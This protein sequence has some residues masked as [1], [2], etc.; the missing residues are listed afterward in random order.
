[1]YIKLIANG[2]RVIQSGDSTAWFGSFGRKVGPWGGWNWDGTTL[3]AKVDRYGMY[4]LFWA[5]LPD[6]VALADSIGALLK[7][8]VS[9]ELDDR[10]IAA[11]LR[12]GFFLGEDTPFLNVRSFPPLGHIRWSH[13]DGLSVEGGQ[14]PRTPDN[15]SSRKEIV[16]G[17]VERFRTAMGNSLPEDQT[18]TVLP[19]SG[20]RDSRHIAL[21]LHRLGF[22]PGLV[23]S[24]RHFA[25]RRDDDADIAAELCAALGW[26]IEIVSQSDDPVGGE[27]RKNQIFDCLTDEHAWLMPSA[28]RINSMQPMA[29][30][31]GLAGDVLSKSLFV[32]ESWLE[33]GRTRNLKGWL[34]NETTR[35]YG[36]SEVALAALLSGPCKKRWAWDV[37]FSRIEEEFNKHAE[38]ENPINSFLFW[39]RTRREIAPFMVRFLLPGVEVITPYLDDDVFDYLWNLPIHHLLDHRLHDEAIALA[40]PEHS[41]IPFARGGRSMSRPMRKG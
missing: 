25:S 9:R 34:Q 7:L 20:G 10:A 39:N 27:L 35:G 15:Q 24:Q 4:P 13:E 18:R 38:D 6:G 1:M 17:Y 29:V 5:R 8:G 22:S 28:A 32:R 2:G 26:S 23:V 41:H 30:F 36:A 16:A 31:D 33:F 21:E 14:W 11:F 40:A 37:A 12:F 3:D 19:L